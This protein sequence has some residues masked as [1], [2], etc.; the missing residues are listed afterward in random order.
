MKHFFSIIL[1]VFSVTSYGQISIGK[2]QWEGE[3]DHSD[4]NYSK[5]TV[6]ILD[7]NTFKL[8]EEITYKQDSNNQESVRNTIV[9]KGRIL[10]DRGYFVLLP[11]D[12]SASYMVKIKGSI[13]I[14]YGYKKEIT[15]DT[16]K[17]EGV[18]LKKASR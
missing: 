1:F 17:L 4:F 7:S 3:V 15:S 12:S 18:R 9:R 5:L 8:T 14:F 13:L 11:E 16:R 10:S 2:Y 6:E